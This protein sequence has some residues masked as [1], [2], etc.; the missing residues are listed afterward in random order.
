[1]SE[2]LEEKIAE[3]EKLVKIQTSTGN[4][5]YDPYMQGMANGMIC[6]LAVLSGDEPEYMDAPER[7]IRDISEDH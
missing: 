6:V 1:M 4:Y 7:W 2:T 3:V 5:D